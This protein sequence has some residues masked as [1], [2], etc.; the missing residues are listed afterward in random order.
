MKNITNTLIPLAFYALAAYSYIENQ[1]LEV[2]MYFLV[3]TSFLLTNL[4][5]T[6]IINT[7]TGFWQALSW[8]FV[9]L[10]AF[11]FVAVLFNDANKELLNL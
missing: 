4:I 9:I 6:K 1:W 7:H 5:R 10:S 11:M 2:S 8:I 3:G